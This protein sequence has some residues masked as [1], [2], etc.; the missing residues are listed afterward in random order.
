[1]FNIVITCFIVL[2]LDISH[3]TIYKKIKL[4]NLIFVDIN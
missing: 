2:I 3:M 1:M 4:V